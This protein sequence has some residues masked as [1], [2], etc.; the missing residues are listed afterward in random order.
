MRFPTLP[1]AASDV[2]ASSPGDRRCFRFFDKITV[3]I[4]SVCSCVFFFYHFSFP[5]QLV[6]GFTLSDLLDKPWSQEGIV[7]SPSRYVPSFLSRIG[8]RIPTAR[9]FHRMLLTWLTLSRFPLIN[10]CKEKSLRVCALGDT[11]TN[12]IV[13][14]GT[15]ITYQATGTP[16]RIDTYQSY[17]SHHLRNRVVKQVAF[18]PWASPLEG[19]IPGMFLFFFKKPEFLASNLWTS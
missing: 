12:E 5:A 10:L 6:G 9:R 19:S 1:G 4:S 16:V 18:N 2:L 3:T 14:V 15:R 7:L 11:W 13:L 17:T 8:S